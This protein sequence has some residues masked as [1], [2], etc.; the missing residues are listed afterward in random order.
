MTDE[1]TKTGPPAARRPDLPPEQAALVGLENV[2]ADFARTFQAS[3][4]RWELL[5]YPAV[6]VFLVMGLS[7]FWLIYSLTRDMHTLAQHVDPLMADNMGDMSKEIA[8]LSS[9][10]SAMNGA[11][12][13]M[14]ANINRMDVNLHSMNGSI[15][16]VETHMMDISRKLNT[17]EP[18]LGTMTQMNQSMRS[19]TVSTG[20]MS[21]DMSHMNYNFARP[22]S[23]MNTFF[24]W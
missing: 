6:L 11:I 10:I 3:A 15:V 2:L 7:G 8:E 9:N 12:Q 1:D 21:R 14:T 5:V 13:Q 24:P 19:M 17:L 16:A 23:F 22:M 18:I 4:R 20:V